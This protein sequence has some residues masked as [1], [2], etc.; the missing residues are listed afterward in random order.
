M[1]VAAA[2][3]HANQISVGD[4]TG[5]R[6]GRIHFHQ[7]GFLHL[8]SRRDIA[9]SG[10]QEVVRLACQQFERKLPGLRAVPRFP[11]RIEYRHRV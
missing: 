1:N 6:V 10:I 3:K 2:V 11:R 8:L 7:T 9:E 5:L 4:F